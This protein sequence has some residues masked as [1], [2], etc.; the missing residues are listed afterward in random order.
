MVTLK[1]LHKGTLQSETALDPA[2]GYSV[3]RSPGSRVVLDDPSVSLNHCRFHA[4]GGQWWVEDI[5]SADG[6]FVDDM[7][8]SGARGLAPG[9]TVRIG[10]YAL[11]IADVEVEAAAPKATL[12]LE[13]KDE[14]TPGFVEDRDPHGFPVYSNQGYE[15]APQP[16]E[17]I[18]V[19][20][21]EGRRPAAVNLDK[22]ITLIGRGE[23][24]DLRLEGLL[25]RS[26]QA[27]VLKDHTGCRII[28]QG[29]FHSL[30]VNGEKVEEAYVVPGDEI[31]IA[32]HR[33]IL[34]QL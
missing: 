34:R 7:R 31:L 24:C 3:G 13:E 16:K 14:N 22:D 23:H 8:I 27:V 9:E 15:K 1:V 20:V 2:H 28:G 4:E 10:G 11:V 30:Q 19:L 6:T 26:E 32:G 21:L 18:L 29:G 17:K 25:V 5:G 12:S 33:L